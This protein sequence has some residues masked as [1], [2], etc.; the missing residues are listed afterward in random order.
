VK[1]ILA[2]Y[3]W[4]RRL[5]WLTTTA[6]LAA[7]AVGVS[8]KW[9]NTAEKEPSV[10]N[11]PVDEADYISPKNVK[12]KSHDK[13]QALAVVSKFIDFAV[14]GENL[15]RSWDLVAPEFRAGITREQWNSG[16]LPVVPFP[17]RNARWKLE[18]SDSDGV[19]FEMALFPTKSSHMKAQVFLIGLH[20]LGHQKRR[21]WVVDSWQAAP[22]GGSTTSGPG[23]G[24]GSVLSQ[25][26]PRLSPNAESRLSAAWLLIPFGLLSL[27]L[28]VPIGVVSVSWYRGHREAR[29]FQRS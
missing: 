26:S 21:H 6:V 3:R 15:E 20:Q 12:L 28:I 2:S 14:V 7:V 19:G 10:S 29:A 18:Y 8:L 1:G 23:G 4:R 9:P 27:I 22:T 25:V 17:V 11:V 16:E 24:G 5:V 13:A